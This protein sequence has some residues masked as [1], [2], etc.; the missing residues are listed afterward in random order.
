MSAVFDVQDFLALRGVVDGS[1]TWP[2]VQRDVND[3]SNQLVVISED[4]GETPEAGSFEGS[5]DAA[6][7]RP[8]VQVLVRGNPNDGPSVAEKME[9]V[10]A[11]LHGRYGVL[12]GSNTYLAV[13]ALSEPVPFKDSKQ[14]WV[15]TL[16]FRCAHH[17]EP[18]LS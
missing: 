17:Q 13:T 11:T 6:I 10:K 16:S 2:S 14:R 4:G 12:M 15:M 18:A 5:G 9:E 1:T 3:S 8:W 7:A